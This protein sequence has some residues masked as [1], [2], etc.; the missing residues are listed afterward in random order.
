M[1]SMEVTFEDLAENEHTQTF[2]FHFSEPELME[3]QF[4]DDEPWSDFMARIIESENKGKLIKEFNWFV[5]EAYGLKSDDNLRFEKSEEIKNAFKQHPAYGEVVNRLMSSEVEA[6]AFINGVFPRS[7]RNR[8]K[9]FE[10][11]AGK[12]LQDMSVEEARAE[13]AKYAET[14][15]A[16]QSMPLTPPAFPPAQ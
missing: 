6:A 7:I 9:E 11:S 15:Q 10:A 4:Q 14:Q 5:L 2:Y 8:T 13:M 3:L 12:S 1:Y 16:A